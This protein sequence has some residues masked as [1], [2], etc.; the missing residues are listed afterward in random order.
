MYIVT[1]GAGF[2]GSAFIH[3]LNTEGI[4]NIIVVDELGADAK[5]KNLRKLRFNDYLHKDDFLARV[6]SGALP[7]RITH[8]IHMGA[9]SST[10]AVNGDLVMAQNFSYSKQIAEFALGKNI[11]FVYA[12]SAA[13][14]GN[15]ERGYSDEDLETTKN[16]LPLNLYGYSKQLFDLW[17]MKNNYLEKIVGLKFF[18]VFGPNEYHKEGQYG[19]AYKFFQQ[20]QAGGAAKLFK[21]YK[22]NIADGEQKRDFVYVKDC[23]EVMWWLASNLQVNGIFNLGSGKARS[24]LDVAKAVAA[25]LGQTPRTE[26][27]EM[28]ENIRSQYQYFTEAKMQKLKAAGCPITPR[29]LEDSVKDYVQGHLLKDDQ[30]L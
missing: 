16:L 25:S 24:F 28:P 12:S 21:S 3:K 14:Y 11:R 29:S 2:I 17:A 5:W 10:T 30:Y 4:D 7:N 6:A 26:F 22:E 23:T 18:N 27:V 1:G 9:I 13:T 19:P 8:I 20:M 15:G